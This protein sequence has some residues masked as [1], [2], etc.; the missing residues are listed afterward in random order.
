MHLRTCLAAV[1]LLSI[2]FLWPRIAA[3]QGGPPPLPPLGPPPVPAEN[4]QTPA[5]IALGQTLFWDEQLS[6]TGTAAC[7]SCHMPRAGGNEPRTLSPNAASV[8]PGPDQ[9]FGTPDDIVGSIGVPIHD[10]A[11]LYQRSALFGMAAQV[12]TRQSQSAINSA[13]PPTLFWDG[14]AAGAF[15]DPDTQQQLIAIGGALE[16]QALGPVVNNVEMAHSGRTLADVS[17]RIASVRPLRLSPGIPSALSSWIA[18]RDYPALF[19]EVFGSPEISPARIALAIASYQRSLVANQT[20]H[21]LQGLG[22]PAM[23]QAELAGRQAFV[24]AGCARC[25]GGPLLSD[26]N[27]HYIGVR[28]QNADPGRFAVT[29]NNADRG[30]MRTPPLRNV[31]L[32]PPYM[33]DGRLRTLEEVVDFYNRGGDFTA[34]NK[35]PRIIPLGLT[36][37]QRAAI[38]TF[39]RR[40]LTDARAHNETGPFERPMLF[41]ESPFAPQPATAGTAGQ[42]GAVPRLIALE[43][44]FAGTR[45]FTIGVDNGRALAS[46]RALLAVA[47]PVDVAADALMTQDFTLDS[48]GAGSVH[49]DLPNGASLEG[50]TLYLRVFVADA[51]AAGGWSSSNSVSF[52]LLEVSDAVFAHGFED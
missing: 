26:N 31:E 19:A 40:P 32:S 15:A 4:P 47:D 8:H 51:A 20:P 28:P 42:G 11:G 35:D 23:T 27:F 12:G 7:G 46:A 43:A 30:R 21:D 29:G 3:A 2:A 17:A 9:L 22:Q 48:S 41:S 37:Q 49:L 34:P 5:K 14:R 52:Q 44:P 25:H 50:V 18:N 16:N 24:Q 6:I 33:A 38:V 36:P 39:L 45:E 13:Y 10:A 1:T